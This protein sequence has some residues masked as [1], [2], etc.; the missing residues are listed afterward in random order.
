MPIQPRL[1][2]T[3][4]APAARFDGATFDPELDRPRLTRLLARV[5]A[6]MRDGE[7]RTLPEIAEACGGTEASVSARL[8]DL[9]KIRFGAYTVERCRLH[10]PTR[11]IYAYRLNVHE[12][13]NA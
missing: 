7:W 10:P 1:F 6:Y 12:D 5:Y 2:D 13:R 3:A 4:A 8:R 9:R 11:G